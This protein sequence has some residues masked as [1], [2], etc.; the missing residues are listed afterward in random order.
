MVKLYAT[1][2]TKQQKVQIKAVPYFTWGNRKPM[3]EMIVW[4]RESQ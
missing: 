3:Q 1:Q 4:L 2:V